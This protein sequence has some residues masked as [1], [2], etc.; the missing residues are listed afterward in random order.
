[1]AVG[2]EVNQNDR[3]FADNFPIF[4]VKSASVYASTPIVK[5]K[6]NPAYKQIVQ[7]LTTCLGKFDES[8]IVNVSVSTRDGT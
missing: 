4:G 5:F 8:W 6:A 1:V 3:Y 7:E 2:V